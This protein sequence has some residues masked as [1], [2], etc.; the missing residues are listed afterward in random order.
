MRK[1]RIAA[2]LAVLF[3][4]VGFA[5]GCGPEKIDVGSVE[6]TITEQYP[7]NTGGLELT[8]ITCEEGN[9]EVDAKF[10]CTGDN[11]A[12]VELE[13]EA[14]VNEV[15]D[16]K[17]DFTWS[18]VKSVSDGSVF[19]DE[20]VATL[21]NQGYAVAEMDCPEIEVKKG[22]EAVCDVTMDNGSAQTATI[23][24]TDDEGGFDVVT[25]GPGSG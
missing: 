4:S 24:L 11:D 18:T 1:S 2:L 9:A 12:G 8:S 16:E 22:N 6:E 21:Q 23:T 25:S 13:I 20:A 7:E 14:T 10:T 19:A 15:T 17:V 5:S 3:V